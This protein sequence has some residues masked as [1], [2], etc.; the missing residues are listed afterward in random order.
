MTTRFSAN[1]RIDNIVYCNGVSSLSSFLQILSLTCGFLSL[2]LIYFRSP[3]F[4]C[5]P[6]KCRISV[7]PAEN[8]LNLMNSV[9][10][11]QYK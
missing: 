2:V 7:F 11:L 8:Q 6:V 9:I 3:V 4:R 5:I 1:L 10:N